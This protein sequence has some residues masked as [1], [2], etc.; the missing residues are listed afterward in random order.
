MK[1]DIQIFANSHRFC[2]QFTSS[3]PISSYIKNTA[4]PMFFFCDLIIIKHCWSFLTLFIHNFLQ[5]NSLIQENTANN[6]TWFLVNVFKKW[7]TVFIPEFLFSLKNKYIFFNF[8]LTNERTSSVYKI[9]NLLTVSIFFFKGSHFNLIRHNCE[10]FKT[11][12]CLKKC[13]E[14]HHDLTK[15]KSAIRSDLAAQS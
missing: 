10:Q 9:F 1:Y 12:F 8:V 4:F 2:F 14:M 15:V 7:Q 3:Y 5:E 11:Y 6:R 13:F